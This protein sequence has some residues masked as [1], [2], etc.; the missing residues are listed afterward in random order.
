MRA[1]GACHAQGIQPAQGRKRD[2]THPVVE[3]ARVEAY[4]SDERVGIETELAQYWNDFP[5]DAK[6]N[7]PR[8]KRLAG[9]LCRWGTLYAGT[10]RQKCNV[11]HRRPSWSSET[12][13]SVH[14]VGANKHAGV[15][16]NKVN[17]HQWA[18]VAKCGTDLPN[19]L[20]KCG[21][22]VSLNP[23]TRLYCEGIA[24]TA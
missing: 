13:R 16:P 24:P 21:L 7:V 14:K 12:D 11:I 3:Q 22:M 5:G 19:S 1:I 9:R 8:G 10:R 15:D 18:I 2:H 17:L 6:V 4:L 20:T 23:L